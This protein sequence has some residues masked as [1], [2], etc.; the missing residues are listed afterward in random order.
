MTLNKTRK[1][2]LLN[3][4]A[5]YKSTPEESIRELQKAFTELALAVQELQQL[6]FRSSVVDDDGRPKDRTPCALLDGQF[7]RLTQTGGA[8]SIVTITHDLGR[9]PQGVIFLQQGLDNNLALIGGFPSGN[10]PPAS[11]TELSL[12]LN[13]VVG[14][15]HILVLF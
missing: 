15:E 2:F 11:E 13:G 1:T 12:V 9:K 4:S 6:T 7:L 3:F 8:G 5:L 14:N 10:I